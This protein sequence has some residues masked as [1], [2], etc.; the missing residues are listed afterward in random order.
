MT[1]KE[2]LN[3]IR[4]YL[5]DEKIKEKDDLLNCGFD[6]L[7]RMDLHMMLEDDYN[8]KFDQMNETSVKKI[9]DLTII[10]SHI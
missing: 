6:S 9:I 2:I 4:N 5:Q 7:D 3:K 1:R 8:I 10:N